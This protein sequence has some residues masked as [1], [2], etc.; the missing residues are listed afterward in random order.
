MEDHAVDLEKERRE[1]RV[2]G[3]VEVFAKVE[4]GFWLA[5]QRRQLLLRLSGEHVEAV[6]LAGDPEGLVQTPQQPVDG[7]P[8][9]VG[10][11]EGVLPD[12]H[13]DCFGGGQHFNLW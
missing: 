1:P 13:D 11:E 8:A 2:A 5:R 7:L 3:G 4:E 9:P 10:G 12:L 6:L